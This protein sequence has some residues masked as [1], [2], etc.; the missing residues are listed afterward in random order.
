MKNLRNRRRAYLGLCGFGVLLVGVVALVVLT[1]GQRLDLPGKTIEPVAPSVY[2]PWLERAREAWE[3]GD[4]KKPFT[5]K[6]IQYGVL[7]RAGQ[8]E[9]AEAITT[10][11]TAEQ[12]DHL[13]IIQASVRCKLGDFAGALSAIGRI[14]TPERADVA[15]REMAVF[16][17]PEEMLDA[18]VQLAAEIQSPK[19]RRWALLE[20][21]QRA[22]G[23]GDISRARELLGQ[24]DRDALPEKHGK[25]ERCLAHIEAMS[26]PNANVGELLKSVQVA[27]LS[28][29]CGLLGD[30]GEFARGLDAASRLNRYMRRQA[31]IRLARDAHRQNNAEWARRFVLQAEE[32]A[33]EFERLKLARAPEVRVWGNRP[34]DFLGEVVLAMAQVGMKEEALRLADE[35]R[36][37]PDTFRKFRYVVR[38]Y[39]L[40]GRTEAAAAY[41]RL[42]PR[43]YAAGAVVGHYLDKGDLDA[44][45]KWIESC[46]SPNRRAGYYVL[47][48]NHLIERARE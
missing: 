1:R 19:E 31:L 43:N 7:C 46:E 10:A 39:L 36:D 11:L 44:A 25:L 9:A 47:I 5:R 29:L 30:R 22:A 16:Y 20:L 26:T 14:R 17:L 38:A 32:T 35:L 42:H 40:C 18:S 45:T 21:A 48:A 12:A 3:A 2:E 34:K 15:R 37:S 28:M 8:F 24:C 4:E 33:R 6:A 23:Q 41:E 27:D 13:F